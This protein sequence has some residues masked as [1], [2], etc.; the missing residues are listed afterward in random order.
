MRTNP[1]VEAMRGYA[2]QAHVAIAGGPPHTLTARK[3]NFPLIWHEP[4]TL[5]GKNGRQEGILTYR[6]K[7]HWLEKDRNYSAEEQEDVRNE[8]ERNILRLIA[9]LENHSHIQCVRLLSCTP[10]ESALT[11]YG[12]IALSVTLEAD[13]LFNLNRHT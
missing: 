9:T 8:I 6:I 5:T 4:L 12:E 3:I 7:L 11:H 1:I 2:Q 13:I 10:A